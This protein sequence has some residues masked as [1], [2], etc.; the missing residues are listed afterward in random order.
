[1]RSFLFKQT[2]KNHTKTKQPK[3]PKHLINVKAPTK[4]CFQGNTDLNILDATNIPDILS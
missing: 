4:A 3:C 1:M 2:K